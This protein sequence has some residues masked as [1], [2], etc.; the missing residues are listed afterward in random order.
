MIIRQSLNFAAHL[1]AGVVL[2]ALLVG[3][4]KA[5][6]THHREEPLEPRYPPPAD[7]PAAADG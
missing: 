6:R 2:G 4:L 1:L 7:A 3:T 5:R